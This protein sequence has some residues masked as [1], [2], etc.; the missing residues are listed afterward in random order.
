MPLCW[1]MNQ[2]DGLP[3]VQS[4]TTQEGWSVIV[5]CVPPPWVIWG[6]KITS[7]LTV[8]WKS[9]LQDGYAIFFCVGDIPDV[10]LLCPL[11]LKDFRIFPIRYVCWPLRCVQC[12]LPLF[13][14]VPAYVLDCNAIAGA[15]HTNVMFLLVI[16]S[17]NKTDGKHGGIKEL[18]TWRG[19][20]SHCW[21][22]T[23]YGSSCFPVFA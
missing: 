6:E 18:R 19:E 10:V 3:Q 2:W 11:N 5:V 13:R 22:G 20:E 23:C 17:P 16:M 9:I 4:I 7:S 12:S 1:C 14:K 21:H 15:L 8:L